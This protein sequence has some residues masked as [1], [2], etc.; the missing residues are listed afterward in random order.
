MKSLVFL[1]SALLLLSLSGCQSQ[2]AV[3]NSR[4]ID[5]DIAA[6]LIRPQI[7]AAPVAE[8]PVQKSD[9]AELLKWQKTRTAKDCERAQ[10]EVVITLKSLY[11]PPYGTL[12]EADVERLAGFFDEIRS[13]AGPVIGK[14]KDSFS[15]TRPYEYIAGLE[16]CV[17]KE[18]SKAYPSGHATLAQLYSLILADL[19]PKDAAKLQA[20]S[21]EIGKDRILGGVHHPTDIISG[22]QMGDL[23]YA[24]VKKSEKYHKTLAKLKTQLETAKP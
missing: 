1:S 10:S 6:A 3:D 15:R 11:G 18:P 9:E 4:Y 23:V 8:S 16:P 19:Y 24:E 5:A 14:V 20:R 12:N 13:Q 22:R 21:V 2:P 17:R 7:P